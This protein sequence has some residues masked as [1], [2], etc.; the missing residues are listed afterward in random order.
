MPVYGLRA[1]DPEKIEVSGRRAFWQYLRLDS[2][3]PNAFSLQEHP[4]EK[5][6]KRSKTLVYFF[7][8]PGPRQTKNVSTSPL[9]EYLKP[10]HWSMSLLLGKSNCCARMHG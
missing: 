4:T 9:K 3:L 2:M 5:Q 6:P 10:N 7:Y 1:M 8:L